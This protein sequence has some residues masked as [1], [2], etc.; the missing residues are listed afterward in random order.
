MGCPCA[1]SN[2]TV[3]WSKDTKVSPPSQPP[4]CAIAPSAKLPPA[5]WTARP[6]STAGRFTTTLLALINAR[7]ASETSALGRPAPRRRTQTSS[8]RH[9]K[10]T[11]IRDASLRTLIAALDCRLSSLSTARARMLVSTVI[12]TSHP[13]EHVLAK[14]DLSSGRNRQRR[15]PQSPFAVFK[16]PC[17]AESPYVNRHRSLTSPPPASRPP[18][19][20]WAGRPVDPRRRRHTPA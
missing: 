1:E 3:S 17:N 11:A 20:P 10:G 8:H 19:P 15:H 5:S 13:P 12:L 14:G 9:G 2:L 4:S 16:G 18:S 6:A 7:R